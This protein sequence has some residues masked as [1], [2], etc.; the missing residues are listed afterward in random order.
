MKILTKIVIGFGAVAAWVAIV[1]GLLL[2]T[3]VRN[4]PAFW[5]Y[6]LGKDTHGCRGTR[7][8]SVYQPNRPNY[9]LVLSNGRPYQRDIHDTET[10]KGPLRFHRGDVVYVCPTRYAG[11]GGVE[12]VDG[13]SVMDWPNDFTFWPVSKKR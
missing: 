11:K 13:P 12:I 1:L 9:I 6:L 2:V 3:S 7:V 5:N 8:I 4:W 10:V